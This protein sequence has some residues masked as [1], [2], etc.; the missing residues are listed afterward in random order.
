MT[1]QDYYET[2]QVA[3]DADSA[4]ID[5]AYSRLREQYN[6]EKLSGAA[7]ELAALAQQRLT[8]I[9]TA[10]AVLSD[11]QRR[12]EYNAEHAA[13]VQAAAAAELPDYR[14]LP[15]AGRGERARD[16]NPRPLTRPPEQAG[17]FAGPIAALI[18]VLGVALVAVIAGLLVT[19]GGSVPAAAPTATASPMDALEEMIARAQSNAE[20]NQ[21]NAQAWLDYANLL[22]DSVQI[23][24]EQAPDTIL[25]QQRL[26]RWLE[27]ANAYQRSLALDPNN[28]VALGDMGAARCF[29]GVGVGDQTFV[30]QGLQDLQAATAA[31]PNDTR[32]LLN[33][34]SCLALAQPPRTNEAIEI[35]QQIIAVSPDGSPIANEAQRL[36]DQFNA[37]NNTP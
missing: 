8:A 37:A 28:P 17:R 34:G 19:G 5:A 7:E 10:Y 2:L 18:T 32:L 25:Y 1:T 13:A 33:M 14:P 35:W 9:E 22:Y 3:P 23:V 26:P 24:R 21:D 31:Q 12:E 4:M 16:F 11:P 29:Y 6:P 15:P 20:Q 36:I 27:A 30:N